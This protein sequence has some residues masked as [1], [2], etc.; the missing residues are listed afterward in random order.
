[1]GAEVGCHGEDFTHEVLRGEGLEVEEIARVHAIFEAERLFLRSRVDCD[2]A[3][4]RGARAYT[5]CTAKW[6]RPPPAPTMT[7]VCSGCSDAFSTA[8]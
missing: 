7:T 1:M 2:D 3:D 8:L 4:A 6:P 5:Y